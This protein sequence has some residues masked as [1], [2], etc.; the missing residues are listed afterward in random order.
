MVREVGQFCG[1]ENLCYRSLAYMLWC[2]RNT[3]AMECENFRHRNIANKGKTNY[4]QQMMIY[5]QSVIPQHV[6]GIF[7]LIIR[8][9]DVRNMLRNN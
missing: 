9:A 5:W 3:G 1:E 7:A 8:R 6:S 2:P 4:M